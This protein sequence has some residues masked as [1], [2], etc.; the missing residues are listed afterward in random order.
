M[1]AVPI[2]GVPKAIAV[3]ESTGFGNSSRLAMEDA[4]RV[5]IFI[6]LIP[7]IPQMKVKTL[8]QT[9]AEGKM[10]RDR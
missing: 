9:E 6:Y 10:K 1:K 7:N 5:F 3:W 4:K 8:F 2:L